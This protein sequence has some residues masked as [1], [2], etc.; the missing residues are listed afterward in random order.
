MKP[1]PCV[2]SV[3]A[4]KEDGSLGRLVNDDH[5]TLNAKMK[6]FRVQGKPHLCLFA[7]RNI[8]PGEEITYNHGDSDWLWRCK[9]LDEDMSQKGPGASNSSSTIEEMMTDSSQIQT[10][11]SDLNQTSP[12]LCP[13]N[14]T[15][16]IN[17]QQ[18]NRPSS[19]DLV[20]S[21]EKCH[22]H[23]L[24]CTTI[25]TFDKCVQCVG[26]VSSFKWLGY[27]CR[28]EIALSD[29]EDKDSGSESDD[30]DTAVSAPECGASEPVDTASDSTTTE[31][32]HDTGHLGTMSEV[33]STV[34]E[35]SCSLKGKDAG[36]EARRVL[37]KTW[38]KAEVAAVMRHFHDHVREGKLATKDECTHCKL[39]EAPILAQR[40]MQ[41]IQDFVLNRGVAAKRG[42][43][44]QKCL[45]E[46]LKSKLLFSVGF[47]VFNLY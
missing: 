20:V 11:A 14:K 29:A 10:T 33:S 42:A 15:A 45:T 16:E 21:T 3:D 27:Q 22:K 18:L 9:G 40:T 5:M 17:Q 44:K 7:V 41:N 37:K 12:A 13:P 6:Y 35:L 24:L 23:R 32:L 36:Q 47:V 19:M 46:K 31:H 26:P 2:H 28:D 43:E 25:S 39:V 8:H 1:C 34:N 4:A 30:G 38:S